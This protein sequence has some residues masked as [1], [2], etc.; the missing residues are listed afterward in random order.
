MTESE[1]MINDLF[2]D[3]VDMG[4]LSTSNQWIEQAINQKNPRLT[5]DLACSR[6]LTYDNAEKILFS[7]TDLN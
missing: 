3:M 7:M 5:M 1:D 2:A 6:L 4:L